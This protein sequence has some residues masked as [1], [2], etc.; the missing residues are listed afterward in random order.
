MFVAAI[1][2][3][4]WQIGNPDGFNTIWQWFGW[5]NQTLSVFTLWAITVY[6]V[7]E[8][9]SFVLTLVPAV[10]MTVVCGTFL[11]VSPMALG[12]GATIGYTGSVVILVA[13]CVCFFAWYGK[14]MR[15]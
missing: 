8:K 5:S 12:L 3:L 13:T 1:A 4:A 6:L 15:A 9:K 10:F 14:T 11:L 2:L 7:Q